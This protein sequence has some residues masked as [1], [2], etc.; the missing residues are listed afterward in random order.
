MDWPPRGLGSLPPEKLV[1][2][3]W[4][5]S[6]EWRGFEE[7][8][9]KGDTRVQ[10]ARGEQHQ[11]RLAESDVMLEDLGD[12]ADSDDQPNQEPGI[13][14]GTQRSFQFYPIIT[15]GFCSLCMPP[16]F[17]SILPF[18]SFVC[19]PEITQWW[20][21]LKSHLEKMNI[22]PR[23]P[24]HCYY[25]DLSHGQERG[26]WSFE[27]LL[28]YLRERCRR[29]GYEVHNTMRSRWFISLLLGCWG[30][31]LLQIPRNWP[32]CQGSQSFFL[33]LS[34]VFLTVP[35]AH[36]CSSE[37]PTVRVISG[38]LDSVA[39]SAIKALEHDAIFPQS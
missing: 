35:A 29:C 4:I 16:S 39:P 2:V 23:F 19:F 20:V 9:R 34:F 7:L 25:P 31:Q 21:G 37:A 38:V 32:H 15:S 6:Q 1:H 30:A 12:H 18:S 3:Q 33:K 5:G 17:Y 24:Q 26:F 27:S 14:L 8:R 22:E 10:R 11:M 36:N 13:W 28:Q